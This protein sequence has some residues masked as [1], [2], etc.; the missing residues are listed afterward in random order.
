VHKQ[1][2]REVGVLGA[3]LQFFDVTPTKCSAEVSKEDEQSR[4]W[5]E[6]LGERRTGEV[7]SL[8]APLKHFRGKGL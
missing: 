2:G 5:T 6:I 1:H 4:R 8:H 7:S 3:L